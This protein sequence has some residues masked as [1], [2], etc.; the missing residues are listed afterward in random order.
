MKR[1]YQDDDRNGLQTIT[2][3]IASPEMKGADKEGIIQAVKSFLKEKYG[4][5]P[6]ITSLKDSSAIAYEKPERK[7]LQAMKNAMNEIYKVLVKTS[8]DK[9]TILAGY[10]LNLER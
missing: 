8:S 4:C 5:D 6:L 9:I 10:D 1:T 3:I 2:I 7:D